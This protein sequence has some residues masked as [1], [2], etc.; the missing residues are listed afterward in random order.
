MS[1]LDVLIYAHD[2]R[3]LG[4]VSRSIGVALALRRLRPELRILLVTGCKATQELIG[5][6]PIDWVKLPSYEA[7]EQNGLS[8][9]TVG[10]SNFSAKET[11]TIRSNILKEYLRTLRPKLVLVDH[12]PDGKYSELVE[13]L[14]CP[15]SSNTIWVLGI[16]AVVGNVAEIWSPQVDKLFLSSY[17]HAL[18][19]GALALQGVQYFDELNKKL[20][21]RAT[22]CGYVSRAVELEKWNG[23]PEIEDNDIIGVAA[24]SWVSENTLNILEMLVEV[25]SSGKTICGKWTVFVGEGSMGVRRTNIISTLSKIP[26]CNVLPFSVKYLGYLKKARVALMYGGYNTI[27]DILWAKVNTLLVTRHAYDD[28]QELH[29]L[30]L[31]QLADPDIRLLKEREVTV[32]TLG[33]IL[34]QLLTLHPFHP[35]RKRL[36]ELDGSEVAAKFLSDVVDNETSNDYT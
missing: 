31:L 15:E 14:N 24:F 2:G 28:E 9:S 26:S 36:V 16:R 1:Q 17:K 18:W 35:Q 32:H 20:H 30:N 12:M 22:P 11:T 21:E 25:L 6:T 3:G 27:T 5:T 10:S 23:I 34:E 13:S 19:Y 33:L 7:I 4:H 29:A 8:I